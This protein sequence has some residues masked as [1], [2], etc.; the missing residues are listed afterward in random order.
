[1]IHLSDEHRKTQLEYLGLS[2]QDLALLHGKQALFEQIAD[3]VVDKLYDRIQAQPHLL[4]II[5]QHSTLERLKHT[6]REYFMSLTSGKIDDEYVQKRLIV[7]HAHSRIGLTTNWYLGT[8]MVYLDIA[9]A[10][11]SQA[12]PGDWIPVVNSL[13]KMFNYD[14]QLVTEAYEAVEKG[15][16]E[17]LLDEQTSLLTG[18]TKAVQE[19]AS[20][21][22]ELSSSSQTVAETAVQTAEAQDKAHEMIRS[23]EKEVEAIHEMGSL[24]REISDQT[25]LLGLNAAIEAARSGEH[26]RGFEVVANEVRKLAANSKSALEQIQAN[27]EQISSTLKNVFD[28]SSTTAHHART[29][30]ASA[31]EL[32]AF[33]N[34]LEQVTL[35]LEQLK[36]TT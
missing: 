31:E 9:T 8:Y 26:G 14:S 27:V 17:H 21:M 28:M 25:H 3:Q 35:D 16:I 2:E 1:M 22:V 34:M 15:K 6:Q 7:G 30:A 32:T 13:S 29:Q 24:M 5:Q 33:V 20:M 10:A 19:L 36:E 12:L 18:V 11:L 23:L 4:Q